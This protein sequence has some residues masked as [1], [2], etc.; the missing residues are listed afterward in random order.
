M[1]NAN[2]ELPIIDW[3]QGGQLTNDATN[4]IHELLVMFS[5]EL[6]ETQLNL[7]QAYDQQN[8]T[9]LRELLHKLQG[10][11]VYCGLLRLKAVAVEISQTMRQT[12]SIPTP[13]LFSKLNHE[14]MAVAQLLSEK[15]IAVK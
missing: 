5:H 7:N 9:V 1:T 6:P 13:E 4:F 14:L 15:G 10:A 11:C 8:L 12:E 2:E 3:T